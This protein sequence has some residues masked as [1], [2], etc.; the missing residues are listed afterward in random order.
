MSLQST[1]AD[2]VI[3]ASVAFAAPLH[4]APMEKKMPTLEDVV[5][6]L[7]ALT[8]ENAELRQEVQAL[9][10]H[11]AAAAS[12]SIAPAATPVVATSQTASA[13]A[14]ADTCPV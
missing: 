12:A 9:K 6:R 5:A 8:R 2:A 4:A 3:G 11:K 13:P 1:F 7:D 10:A 14:G